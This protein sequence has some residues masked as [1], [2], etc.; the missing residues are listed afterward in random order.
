MKKWPLHVTLGNKPCWVYRPTRSKELGEGDGVAVE[1]RKNNYVYVRALTHLE[2][3]PTY[4]DPSKRELY[5]LVHEMMHAQ[6][7]KKTEQQVEQ[8]SHELAE[9]LWALGYRR[10][11]LPTH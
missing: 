3:S 10:L 8:D 1:G 11:A 6:D 4:P 5:L 2:P 7:F 9:A